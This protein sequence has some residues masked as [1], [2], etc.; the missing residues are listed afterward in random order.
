MYYLAER[1]IAS[2]LLEKRQCIPCGRTMRANSTDQQQHTFRKEG[3]FTG[4]GI[5]SFAA[6]EPGPERPLCTRM[7]LVTGMLIEVNWHQYTPNF[8][9]NHN[10][11]KAFGSKLRVCLI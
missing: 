4:L 10:K 2:I 5:D 8:A 1:I 9:A 6:E 3:K 7:Q 11:T